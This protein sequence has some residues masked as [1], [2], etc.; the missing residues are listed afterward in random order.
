MA[1]LRG[2]CRIVLPV[3]NLSGKQQ[4]IT[5]DDADIKARATDLFTS[6]KEDGSTLQTLKLS[7]WD[8]KV[9]IF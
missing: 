6:K 7:A 1:N 3:V 5:I 4:K 2:S 9:Y 8:Y